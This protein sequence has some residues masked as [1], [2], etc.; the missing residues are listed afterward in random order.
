MTVFCNVSDETSGLGGGPDYT[1]GFS[2]VILHNSHKI[3][4]VQNSEF[5]SDDFSGLPVCRLRFGDQ[6]RLYYF[7]LPLF[8]ELD[9]R[10]TRFPLKIH[11]IYRP[12]PTGWERIADDQ[13]RGDPPP[14][15]P[16]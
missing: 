12:G 8:H 10:T 1:Y 7:N 16:D 3:G 4:A 11:G 15:E 5:T 9:P 6:T 14:P 13:F 2:S